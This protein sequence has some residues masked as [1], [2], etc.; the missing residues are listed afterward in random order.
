M[1]LA[2][3][4]PMLERVQELRIHSC[5]ASQVLGIY[6]I[7]LAFVGVDEPQLARVRHK[8]LVA[9]LLQESRLTQGEWVPVSMA[10]R[11]GGRSE[12]K[13]LLRASGVV[14]SLP[15]SITSPLR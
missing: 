10:M 4:A 6:F 8:D 9:A 3:F 7:R 2:L 13:R 15:S 14:R 11:I 1:G 12:A 5:Q